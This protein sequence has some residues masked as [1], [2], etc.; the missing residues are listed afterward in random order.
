MELALLLIILW[1]C[2]EL[3]LSNS[4]TYLVQ[5]AQSASVGMHYVSNCLLLLFIYL[6]VLLFLL[7]SSISSCFYTHILLS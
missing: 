1:V 3:S 6:Y 5:S 2:D 4:Y 7:H